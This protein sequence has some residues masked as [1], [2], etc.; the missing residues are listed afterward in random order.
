MHYLSLVWFQYLQGNLGGQGIWWTGGSSYLDPDDLLP[1]LHIF[2]RCLET[3]LTISPG[4]E[5]KRLHLIARRKVLGTG[6]KYA[7]LKYWAGSA[8]VLLTLMMPFAEGEGS[9]LMMRESCFWIFCWRFDYFSCFFRGIFHKPLFFF[10]P[11]II[12][13]LFLMIFISYF[14]KR[15]MKLSSHNFPMETREPVLMLSDKACCAFDD[16]L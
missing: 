6:L 1:L 10:V 7:P 4:Q 13:L 2:G 11:L 5:V 15:A 3:R 14:V 12:I 16:N 9:V 8:F